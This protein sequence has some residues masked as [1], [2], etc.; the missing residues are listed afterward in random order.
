MLVAQNQET[1]TQKS[2]PT[3]SDQVFFNN[4]KTRVEQSFNWKIIEKQLGRNEKF[5][6]QRVVFCSLW[7]GHEFSSHP[8]KK[9]V[10]NSIQQWT[11]NFKNSAL[12]YSVVY[13]IFK[14]LVEE[15]FLIRE[16]F[17]ITSGSEANKKI[18]LKTKNQK[19]HF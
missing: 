14:Q 16:K 11:K 18:Q 13:K 19:H 6:L 10:A 1:Q 9:F 2:Y 3:N 17:W 5:V 12:S 8:G 15:G 7:Y 4:L